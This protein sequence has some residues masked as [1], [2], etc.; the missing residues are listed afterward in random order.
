VGEATMAQETLL[1]K[2]NGGVMIWELSQDAQPP[3]S[4]LNVIQ[5]NL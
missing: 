2:Q 3:H 4:L 1:G 5:K